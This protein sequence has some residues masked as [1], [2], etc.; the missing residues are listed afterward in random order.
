MRFRTVSTAI[1]FCLAMVAALPASAAQLAYASNERGSIGAAIDAGSKQA[2]EAAA[3][4]RCGGTAN[5]CKVV[6]SVKGDCMASVEARS[7]TGGYWYWVGYT[8]GA[9]AYDRNGELDRVRGM[10]WRWCAVD[11][12]GAPFNSCRKVHS[13]C[14][15]Y[16][17]NLN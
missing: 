3:M 1:A 16:I 6:M 15:S 2:T 7:N 8:T 17:R 5:G 4:Q 14:A 12:S 9:D 10:V 13:D 11:F